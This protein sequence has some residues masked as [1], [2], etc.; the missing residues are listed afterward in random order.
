MRGSVAKKLRKMIFEDSEQ[1][2]TKYLRHNQTG[3]IVCSGLRAL[4]LRAKD[5]Y[6]QEAK[7]QQK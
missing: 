1:R 6:K 2:A 3:V 5:R 7:C 4:Y